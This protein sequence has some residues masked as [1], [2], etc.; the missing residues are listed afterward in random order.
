MLCCA[1]P[2]YPI[3]TE[4]SQ[5]A[6]SS[7]MS[8]GW[9]RNVTNSSAPGDILYHQT[10][11]AMTLFKEKKEA[12]WAN[13]T[14]RRECCKCGDVKRRKGSAKTTTT[15]TAALTKSPKW[16]IFVASVCSQRPIFHQNIINLLCSASFEWTSHV[17]VPL[18]PLL[19]HVL[20]I[21]TPNTGAKLI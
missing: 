13:P 9:T 4:I 11:Q 14:E 16:R 17:F 3:R 6:G 8:N 1:C 2:L 18:L 20:R 5:R 10:G 19:P 15:L 7:Y 12:H 21:K